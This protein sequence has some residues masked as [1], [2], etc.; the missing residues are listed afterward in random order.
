MFG[1]LYYG[2]AYFGEGYPAIRVRFH[3]VSADTSFAPIL[4]TDA[5]FASV[6]P[7]DAAGASSTGEDTLP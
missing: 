7:G 3:V 1:A 6:V 5:A 4:E 2:Q